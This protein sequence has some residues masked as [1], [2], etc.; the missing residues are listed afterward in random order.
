MPWLLT[1]TASY[2]HEM[3]VNIFIYVYINQTVN[4]YCQFPIAEPSSLPGTYLI[5]TLYKSEVRIWKYIQCFVW[6]VLFT[7][8][9]E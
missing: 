8:Q 9:L 7:I 6:D 5:Y 3:N 4:S 2:L 1:I